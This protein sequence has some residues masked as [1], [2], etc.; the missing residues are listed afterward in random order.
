ML[1]KIDLYCSPSL[2]PP[3]RQVP[4]RQVLPL[5]GALSTFFLPQQEVP[6]EIP[7]LRMCWLGAKS[8]TQLSH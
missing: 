2:L 5:D 4:Q 6:G 8:K 1:A 3:M 7:V